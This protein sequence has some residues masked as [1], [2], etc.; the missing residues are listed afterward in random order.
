MKFGNLRRQNVSQSVNTLA[1]PMDVPSIPRTKAMQT[2][3]QGER[4]PFS[5]IQSL[6]VIEL[7]SSLRRRS[8]HARRMNLIS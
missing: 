3:E 4:F 2:L 6:Y 7:K 5:S 8:K 1:P